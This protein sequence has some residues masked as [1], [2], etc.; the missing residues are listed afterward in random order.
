MFVLFFC[1]VMQL[2]WN[3]ALM[4]FFVFLFTILFFA[5]LVKQQ[6][7]GC[8][9]LKRRELFVDEEFDNAVAFQQETQACIAANMFQ[10]MFTPEEEASFG[11]LFGK[12]N[13]LRHQ[14]SGFCCCCC[15]LVLFHETFLFTFLFFFLGQ[16]SIFALAIMFCVSGSSIHDD[17]FC[18]WTLFATSTIVQRTFFFFA[19]LPQRTNW[20]CFTAVACFWLI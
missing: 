20:L 10:S 1:F 11:F 14:V 12:N 17:S 5:L 19:L 16:F 4:F 18:L 6:N 9:N 13:F 2:Y 3:I 8:C 15:C 7:V